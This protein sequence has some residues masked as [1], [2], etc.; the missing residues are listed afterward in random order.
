M[1]IFW[2]R[3]IVRWL[4]L[5]AGQGFRNSL[6]RSEVRIAWSRLIGFTGHAAETASLSAIGG[7]ARRPAGRAHRAFRAEGD[8]RALDTFSGA[9]GLSLGLGLIA[10]CSLTACANPSEIELVVRELGDLNGGEDNDYRIRRRP[11]RS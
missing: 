5:W 6:N 8:L 7:A 3:R 11:G 10:F 1:Q 9:G 4:R 2:H